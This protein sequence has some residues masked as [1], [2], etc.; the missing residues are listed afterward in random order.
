MSRIYHLSYDAINVEKHFGKDNY[1]EARRYIL[2]VLAN[3]GFKNISSYCES[4]FLIEY[5]T[6]Q[7]KLF[8]YLQINLK[9]YFHYSI[10]MMAVDKFGKEIASHNPK[11]ILNLRLVVEKHDL[12]CDKIKKDITPY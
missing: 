5:N 12:S 1:K 3:T 10:S 8:N 9:Q 4:T 6:E 2:C 7:H 11:S